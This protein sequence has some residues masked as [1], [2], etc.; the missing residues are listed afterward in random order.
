MDPAPGYDAKLPHDMAHFIVENELGISGGVFGQLAS[1]G[2]AGTFIPIDVDKQR[3]IRR[4][5]SESLPKT[6]RTRRY[7]NSLSLSHLKCG[8]RKLK[9]VRIKD[10]PPQIF[11]VWFASLMRQ[12]R[13]GPNSVWESR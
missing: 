10:S 6:K 4:R 11:R 12:A 8:K 3:R 5:V 9:L 13:S 2:T 7:L 1:G